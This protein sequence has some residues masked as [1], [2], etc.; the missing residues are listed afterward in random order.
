MEVEV[1]GVTELVILN[2]PEIGG[3]LQVRRG[4]SYLGQIGR[5]SCRERV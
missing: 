2:G 5:A 3:S 1:L 4:V